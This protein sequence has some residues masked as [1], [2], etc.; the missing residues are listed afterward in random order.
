MSDNINLKK[1]SSLI[2]IQRKFR[3]LKNEIDS[4]NK[5]IT[6]YKLVLES[7]INNL[8]YC[9]NL[10]IF[11]DI[12]SSYIVILGEL[13]EIKDALDTFPEFVT[14]KYVNTEGLTNISLRLVECK[15]L[16]LKYLNHIAPEN[17]SY[18]L[19]L[20]FNEKWFNFFEKE[21]LEKIFF[22]SKFFIPICLWE[23]EVHKHEINIKRIDLVFQ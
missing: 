20:I 8:T 18:I 1:L 4:K 13:K 2:K 7:M 10:K 21:D 15:L 16:I 6:F 3:F 5:K 17:L 12:N 19:Q 11:Q 22:I 14:I 23:S 9:N